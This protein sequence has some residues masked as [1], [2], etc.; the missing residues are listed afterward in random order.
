[1]F[2]FLLF[3]FFFFCCFW[4]SRGNFFF[5]LWLRVKT[6]RTLQCTKQYWNGFRCVCTIWV[7]KKNIPLT[8]W[9]PCYPMAKRKWWRERAWK[10]I[11]RWI[12]I[13][14]RNP[15]SVRHCRAY[16]C[17]I[18]TLNSAY[19]SMYWMLN[20]SHSL[21]SWTIPSENIEQIEIHVWFSNFHFSWV[22]C[23]FLP[24]PHKRIHTH[25]QHWHHVFI[26]FHR[27]HLLTLC[28]HENKT[29]LPK[30]MNSFFFFFG[31]FKHF[32]PSG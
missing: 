31:F 13:H 8:E 1:M 32:F 28:R 9:M 16:L 20:L 23:W 3:S 21:S 24:Y 17:W 6:N 29:S 7:E 14:T 11:Q 18:E 22:N 2:V 30:V 5:L 25:T 12:Y 19:I 10:P 15:Y 27:V 26:F 4:I